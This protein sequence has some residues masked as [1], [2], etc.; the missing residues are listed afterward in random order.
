M[1]WSLSDLADSALS[2]LTERLRN[3]LVRPVKLF[4]PVSLT[5]RGST[6]RIE[7]QE[8]GAS[9]HSWAEENV[10]DGPPDCAAGAGN[11]WT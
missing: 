5:E 4:V 10:A 7:R 11:T 8:S 3:P 9:G 6:R 2:R 1:H